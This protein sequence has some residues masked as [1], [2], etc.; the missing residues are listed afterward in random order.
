MSLIRAIQKHKTCVFWGVRSTVCGWGSGPFAAS[1]FAL[2]F[3][4]PGELGP[5]DL[6]T[7]IDQHALEAKVR[8]VSLAAEILADT[9]AFVAAGRDHE[10]G[11]PAVAVNPYRA[12]FQA[13]DQSQRTAKVPCVHTSG[14]TIFG[15]LRKRERFFFRVEGL[16]GQHGPEYFLANRFGLLR[17]AAQ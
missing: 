15:V 12:G 7:Q 8:F 11:R 2:P 16:Q 17:H 6:L 14:E 9:R 1:G 13:A 3:A 10:V 5:T 4:C